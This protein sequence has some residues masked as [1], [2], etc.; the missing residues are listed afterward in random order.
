MAQALAESDRRRTPASEQDLEV[1]VQELI[2]A[3]EELLQKYSELAAEMKEIKKAPPR[4]TAQ[5]G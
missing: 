2:L 3:V 4:A 1:I 5:K